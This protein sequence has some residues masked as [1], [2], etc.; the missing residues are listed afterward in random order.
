MMSQGRVQSIR[1]HSNKLF[2]VT[3]KNEVGTIQGMINHRLIQPY[4]T[5]EN[6]KLFSRMIE[7]GDHICMPAFSS[8]LA[9]ACAAY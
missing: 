1:R 9:C 8:C 2:F 6:F 5:K 7:R 3:I 4:V